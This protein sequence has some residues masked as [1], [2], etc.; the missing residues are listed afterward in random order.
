M[1]KLLKA[2]L[3][4]IF[5]LLTIITKGQTNNIDSLLC[6]EWK[7]LA[8]EGDSEKIT[9]T[10]EQEKDRVIFYF[11]HTVKSIEGGN[12]QHGIWNYDATQKKLTVVYHETK[13]K[14]VFKLITINKRSFIVEMK[15]L[16]GMV[17]KIHM[18]PASR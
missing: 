4:N 1:Q 5:L 15:D 2:L 3:I 18:A 12:I 13:E 16:D 10:K 7:F 11:D 14:M 8:Y 17:F 9:V 6:K